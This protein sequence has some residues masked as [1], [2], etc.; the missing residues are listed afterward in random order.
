MDKKNQKYPLQFRMEGQRQFHEE[1]SCGNHR[2]GSMDN[3]DVV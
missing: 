1:R 3:E 2:R